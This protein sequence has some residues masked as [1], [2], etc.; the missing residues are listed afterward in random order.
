MSR[1]TALNKKDGTWSK[2]WQLTYFAQRQM[3]ECV[4]S[5]L[6]SAFFLSSTYVA[7]DSRSTGLNGL[8]ILFQVH[9]EAQFYPRTFWNLTCG[10]IWEEKQTPAASCYLETISLRE[11]D[12]NLKRKQG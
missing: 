4:T 1:L 2:K 9:G 10:G 3:L 11:T 8:I 7:K 12:E 6:V 5:V